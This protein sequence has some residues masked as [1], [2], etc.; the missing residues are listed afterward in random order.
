MHPLT[1]L[2]VEQIILT[3][4]KSAFPADTNQSPA[5]V[6]NADWV[7]APDNVSYDLDDRIGIDDTDVTGVGDG[8]R[9]T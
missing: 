7:T 8:H 3:T 4:E 6:L 9:R 1:I 5:I 2:S